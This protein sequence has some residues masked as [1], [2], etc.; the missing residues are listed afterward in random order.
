MFTCWWTLMTSHWLLSK[1]MLNIL[2][3]LLLLFFLVHIHIGINTSWEMCILCFTEYCLICKTALPV[4]ILSSNVLR[5]FIHCHSSMRCDIYFFFLIPAKSLYVNC[6]VIV[7][8]YYLSEHFRDAMPYHSVI[9]HLSFP[10][11]N[12]LFCIICM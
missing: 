9:H 5:I 6:Y 1:M 7:F 2:L 11:I 3:H 10:Y 8:I 12:S 4:L